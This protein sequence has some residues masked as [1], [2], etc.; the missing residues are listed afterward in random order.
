MVTLAHACG[1]TVLHG[2]Q[3]PTAEPEPAIDTL[4]GIRIEE[5]A[6]HGVITSPLRLAGMARGP[7]YFEATFPVKLLDAEGNLVGQSF[8]QATRDW[9]TTDFVPFAGTLIFEAP[10]ASRGVIVFEKANASGLP[11]HAGELRVPVRFRRRQCTEASR[12]RRASCTL[13]SLSLPSAASSTAVPLVGTAITP[14][15]RSGKNTIAC[16]SAL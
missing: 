6:T 10:R 1:G 14:S 13:S 5:P 7:W 16:A 2:A 8:V 15:T 11:E 12:S 3:T 9:M 4:D